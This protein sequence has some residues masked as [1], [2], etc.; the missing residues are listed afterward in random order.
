M[1]TTKSSPNDN[2]KGQTNHVI[3]EI[4]LNYYFIFHINI[5]INN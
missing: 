5:N 4:S 1:S 3:C 2:D